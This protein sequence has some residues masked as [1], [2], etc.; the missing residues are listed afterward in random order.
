[1]PRQVFFMA[2]ESLLRVPV[3]GAT[4]RRCG[5]FAVKPE[6][7]DRNAIR[8]AVTLLAEGKLVRIFPEGTRSSTGQLQEPH[9]GAALIASKARVPLIPMA[10]QGTWDALP[11]N[12]R[13]L[14]PARLTLTFG[15]PILPQPAAEG[16]RAEL[17]GT[18]RRIMEAIDQLLV[19]EREA[20]VA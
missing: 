3:L 11:R 8:H 1:V 19:D 2:R 16:R 18:S 9:P 12:A 4:L 13:W 5:V 7:A 6:T 15:P 14:R 10:I 20:A 17:A